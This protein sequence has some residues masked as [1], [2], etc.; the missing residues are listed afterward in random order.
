MS[1]FI[2]D[3]TPKSFVVRGDTRDSK[4]SLKALGGKWNSSL[5]D[6]DS[7][8]KF[9]AWLFWSDKRKELDSWIKKGCP[10]IDTNLSATTHVST[11]SLASNNVEKSS[12]S[13]EAKIDA[14]TKMVEQLC[15]YH[16][17]NVSANVKKSQILDSDI[18]SDDDIP[19]VKPKRLLSK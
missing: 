6:K 14:L 19:I 9:G 5:T 17:I 11:N 13:I 2:E 16:Q 15:R 8:D 7:G 12:V 1:I 4:D 10:K 18:E 3:Y